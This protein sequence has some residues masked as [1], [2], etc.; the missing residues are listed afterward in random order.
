MPQEVVDTL[1]PA[2]KKI[3][4]SEEFREFM[5]SRG[6]GVVWRGPEE[7]RAFMAESNESLGTVMKAV[8]IAQ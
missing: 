8:G 6:F 5:A 7:F 1:V 3:H 2:L 4:D